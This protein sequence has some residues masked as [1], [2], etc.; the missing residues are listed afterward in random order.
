MELLVVI[1]VVILTFVCARF[2]RWYDEKIA[3]ET[4]SKI[5]EVKSKEVKNTYRKCKRKR[6]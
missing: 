5:T 4:Y 1:F 2:N 6:I 3:Y